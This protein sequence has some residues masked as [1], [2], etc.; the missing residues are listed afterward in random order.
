MSRALAGRGIAFVGVVCGLLA[1]GLTLVGL[2][3]GNIAAYA[4]HG[5][6]SAFL[7]VT[8]A[9]AS[10]LPAEV[11]KDTSGAVV[12]V[13]AFGFF[14][15]TPAVY[16]FNQLDQLGAAAWLGLCTILI[17]IGA[18][19]VRAAE[20]EHTAEA[21]PP[22][23]AIALR[24]PLT[25]L[26][27]LGVGLVVVG[28]WLPL[29]SGGA[30]LWNASASGHA[31]GLL[32]LLVAVLAVVAILGPLVSPAVTRFRTLLIA[33]ATF[34]LVEAPFIHT[35]FNQLGSLGTGGWL[36]AV[37]GL[38]LFGGVVLA[39]LSPAARAAPAGA[40]AATSS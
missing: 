18:H 17:P 34:G 27:L 14:L 36:A 33:A 15:F 38:L 32:L 10:Y 20:G 13:V 35:A 4:D 24:N 21:A 37:G 28:I 29:E 40:A 31:L 30:S 5:A 2:G 6:V 1:L 23:P 12:G 7:I 16:A 26:A 25:S 22:S 11:G 9:Y 3:G 8:L 19:V 39:P